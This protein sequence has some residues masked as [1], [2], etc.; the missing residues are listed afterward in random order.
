MKNLYPQKLIHREIKNFLES[1][2]NTKENTNTFVLT[3]TVPRE[4]FMS[5]VKRFAKTP[6]ATFFSPIKW[7]DLF[8]SKDCLPVALK[9]LVVFKFTSRG[10][11]SCYIGKTK[12]HL[13]TRIK[14][15]L[16]TDTKSH[17]LQ[18]LNEDPNCRDLCDD[19]CFKIID[20]TSLI[21]IILS[22]F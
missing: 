17:I 1:K 4:K 14:K 20:H 12:R 5:Y 16:K 13:P 10:C 9:S 7:H 19:S 21:V 8:S 18:H 22:K 11:P 15:H 6:V 3:Q 2:F